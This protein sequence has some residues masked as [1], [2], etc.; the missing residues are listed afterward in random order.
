MEKA[1]AI[2]P[3]RIAWCCEEQ[4][5]SVDQLAREVKI[6]PATLGRV[7][8]GEDALSIKQLRG[9][10]A[11]FNRGLLF[12][13]EPEPVNETTLHSAQFRT[14]RN[15]KP[16]LSPRLKT[17]VERVEYQRRVY[18]SLLED[19]GEAVDREWYP[20]GLSFD[21]VDMKQ[22][23][24]VA[25]RWLGIEEGMDFQ[26]LRRAVETKGIMV[27][28]SNGYAGQWQ[29]AKESPVR[30]F[31]LYFDSYPVIAIKK[32][33]AEGPQ[34][35][36][37]MH[38]L[39]HLLLHRESFID[40]EEDFHSYRGKEQVANAFA[41]NLLVPDGLLAQ[42]DMT[43]FPVGEVSA[44]DNYLKRECKRWCVSG[45]VVVLRLVNEG[46]LARERYPE[47]RKWKETLP[48]PKDSSGGSRYR[49]KEPMR[50]FGEPFVRTVLDALHSRQITLARAS[51]YLDNLKIKDLRRLEEAHARI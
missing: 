51:S 30:G 44:Y 5:L 12:F 21:P 14:L 3:R 49:Y 31:S 13:L 42:V 37:L 6:A 1:H 41:A 48:L 34:A 28:L 20:A 25:R 9:I 47:Y 11:F 40:D 43:H 26:A 7:M 24:A 15:H 50:V 35:F 27:F 17:L 18:L 45:E 4:G 8:E 22:P 32:Q 46:L 10:A 36:T 16:T 19:L 29:I 33:G 38:E 39:A 2:N 23:A